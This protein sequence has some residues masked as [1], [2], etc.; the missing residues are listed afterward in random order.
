MR[1][2]PFRDS[3]GRF[4]GVQLREIAP[5]LFARM[6]RDALQPLAEPEGFRPFA[7]VTHGGSRFEVPHPEFI[8]IPP[9]EET[10]F[11]IVYRPGRTNRRV[12]IPKFVDLTAIDH[13]DFELNGS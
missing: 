2:L 3:A 6:T 12:S 7:I 5:R 9:G 1:G 4:S 8:E 11:V 13:V 10:P